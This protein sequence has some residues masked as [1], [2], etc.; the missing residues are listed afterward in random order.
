VSIVSPAASF[1]FMMYKREKEK[2]RATRGYVYG[3]RKNHH[4]HDVGHHVS[5]ENTETSFII[6][7]KKGYFCILSLS[8]CELLRLSARKQYAS[9][10]C[11]TV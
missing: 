4:F 10:S 3:G 8:F 5:R 9:F 1:F 6:F 2:K 11:Q 7:K